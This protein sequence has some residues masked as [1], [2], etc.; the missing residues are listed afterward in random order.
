MYPIS[1][2]PAFA[3]HKDFSV[4][5][6]V[7]SS[8]NL[9]TTLMSSDRNRRR[10]AVEYLEKMLITKQGKCPKEIHDNLRAVNYQFNQG[11]KGTSI[12]DKNYQDGLA[13]SVDALVTNYNDNPNYNIEKYLPAPVKIGSASTAGSVF[14]TGELFAIKTPNQSND[15]LYHEALIGLAALNTLRDRVPNFM[16]TYGLY[17]CEPPIV[18]NNG[19]V[20]SWCNSKNDNNNTTYLVLENIIHPISLKD[21]IGQLSEA[22]FLQIFLQIVNALNIAYKDF[23]FTHYDLHTG[24]ILIQKL[25]RDVYV[26]LYTPYK[27]IVYI[28]TRII[29]RIIDYGMSHIYYQGYHFGAFGL[30][31]YDIYDNRS[32]P[33]Y[34]IYKLLLFSYTDINHNSSPLLPIMDYIYSFFNE[35]LSINDRYKRHQ[36]RK[37]IGDYFQPGNQHMNK[38]YEHVL[39]HILH[40]YYHHPSIH[41]IAPPNETILCMNNCISWSQYLTSIYNINKL[42]SNLTEYCE[43]NK[44][45]DEFVDDNYKLQLRTWLNQVNVTKFFEH[46]YYNKLDDL[47]YTIKLIESLKLPNDLLSSDNILYYKDYLTVMLDVKKFYI[48]IV[49]WIDAINCSAKYDVNI[50]DLTLSDKYI[51]LSDELDILINHVQQQGY[52]INNFNMK[53]PFIYQNSD[54]M[55]YV[56]ILV[57]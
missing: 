54:I 49:G 48:N 43:A 31:S 38:T 17:L 24:N 37:F 40:K 45:V 14:R 9:Y 34:D 19:T 25:P 50:K 35:G 28:K 27:T 41:N 57:T 33:M 22:E 1:N 36:E 2:I 30:S 42:P 29:P 39:I 44:A 52:L 32:F 56:N 53:H 18:D 10:F 55:Q 51:K 4:S 7:S 12:F 21:A 11:Q 8:K 3:P 23:D 26:P 16:H 20:I 13:C 6:V 15:T 47:K 46:E 5:H